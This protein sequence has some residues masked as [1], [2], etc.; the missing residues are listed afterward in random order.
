MIRRT[1]LVALALSAGV[2][3]AAMAAS[4]DSNDL[5]DGHYEC[6]AGPVGAGSAQKMFCRFAGNVVT[7]ELPDGNRVRATLP[8]TELPTDGSAVTAHAEDQSQW[9]VTLVVPAQWGL[10]R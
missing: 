5:D 10:D 3:G 1:V 9:R 8:S 6:M 7:L 2:H 4:Y